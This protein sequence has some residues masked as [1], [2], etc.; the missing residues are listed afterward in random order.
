MDKE[1]FDDAVEH[2][3]LTGCS[4]QE[5]LLHVAAEP[6]HFVRHGPIPWV[7]HLSP[8]RRARFLKLRHQ[9]GAEALL[10][11]AQRLAMVSEAEW[12]MTNWEFGKRPPS[13]MVR[14]AARRDRLRKQWLTDSGTETRRK[15][16]DGRS[17]ASRVMHTAM[18]LMVASYTWAGASAVNG[19]CLSCNDML[20]IFVANLLAPV[21][22]FSFFL[23][24][25]QKSQ[26]I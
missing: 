1:F 8:L 16:P 18:G 3:R 14:C 11:S 7:S 9:L 2:A 21:A 19:G 20:L 17:L 12:I 6:K 23:Q 25:P 10:P 26:A 24:A 13:L 22:L 15:R 4:F 5:A